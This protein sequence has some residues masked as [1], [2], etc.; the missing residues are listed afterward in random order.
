MA[1]ADQYDLS[2]DPT[3]IKRMYV[4]MVTAA[5]NVAGETKSPMGDVKYSKRQALATAVLRDPDAHLRMFSLAVVQNAAITGASND[6]DIQFT[7]NS[8]WDD[9]AGVTALD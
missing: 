6:G 4:A 3:F 2:Q 1:Y 7:A 8:V 5:I 9:L